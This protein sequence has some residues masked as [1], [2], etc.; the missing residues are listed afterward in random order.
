VRPPALNPIV[1]SRY[2][3]RRLL[4]TIPLLLAISLLQFVL[5]NAVPS[6]YLG[7]LCLDPTVSVA[8]CAQMKQV[9]GLDQPLPVRY[10]TWMSML[11]RGDLGIAHSTHRPVSQ[12]IWERLPV[13]LA[14]SFAALLVSYSI[15]IPLGIYAGLHRGSRADHLIRFCTALLNAIPH[16]WLALLILIALANIKL[17]TGIWILPLDRPTTLGKPGFDLADSLWH[18][19]LPALMLGMGGWVSFSRYLRSETLEVLGQDYVRVAQAKGLAPRLVVWR[20]V[21]RNALIPVLTLSSGVLV[22]LV[23]G[24]VIYEDIFSWPGMG[25]LLLHAIQKSDYPLSGGIL[26]IYTVLAVLG[27]LLV[28]V[29]YSWVDPRIRYE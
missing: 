9:L 6:G 11:L 25:R 23:S 10:W 21:L 8:D 29:T 3:A 4:Q 28:D 14:L 15:G 13:T 24:S 2:L 26:Y 20:H 1:M 5:I 22:T 16:W 19:I 7:E 18:L 17:A 27:R 12:E